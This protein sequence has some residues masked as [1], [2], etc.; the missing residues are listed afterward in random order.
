EYGVLY[1]VWWLT[2]VVQEPR[3][4]AIRFLQ[5]PTAFYLAGRY[6]IALMGALA[7]VAVWGVARRIYNPRVALGAALIGATAFDHGANSH[8]INVHVPTVMALW[9]G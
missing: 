1:A 6:T 3:D 7:C 9:M 4:F 5:D 8:L 2:G